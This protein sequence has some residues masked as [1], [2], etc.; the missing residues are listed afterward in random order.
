M[1][2]LPDCSIII[3]SY[4]SAATIG[5]CLQALLDQDFAYPYE[6]IVVDSSTDETV[7]IVRDRY[8]QVK[9][10]HLAHQT[11]P[12]VARNIGA[13]QA[14]GEVLAFID[15]DCIAAPDWLRRL[16]ETIQSGCEAAG[17]AISN[18]NGE[19]MVSW[20]GY[21][22]EFREFLPGGLPTAVNNLTLGN[23]A[24]RR[25]L[26]WQVGG[27]PAHFFPQEDQV[28]HH[29]WYQR[30]WG[31]WF[32]PLIV[33]AHYHRTDRTAFLLHQYQIGR[34]NARVLR[35]L[36]RPGALIA[37]HSWLTWLASPALVLL[38]FGR[39][40]GACWNLERH[41]LLRQP[42][43]LWLCWLGMCWWGRGFLAEAGRRYASP[44]AMGE[45]DCVHLG[46]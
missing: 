15:A 19:S 18:A 6:I 16:Y 13:K 8:P 4:G 28:F 12:A 24:Y 10:I 43:L 11:D 2:D 29:L 33:V 21:M 26:F 34:A 41:L 46:D 14:G 17:G 3:P 36:N 25:A 27:F 5:A 31:I 39:T 37:R 35:L 30:G 23:S 32:D 40:I 42:V 38:R 9:L 44:P 45:L 7:E 20:A 22:C 1:S